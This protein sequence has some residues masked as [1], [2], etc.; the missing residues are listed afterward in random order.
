MSILNLSCD[1]VD[2]LIPGCEVE[3]VER[4][5][6]SEMSRVDDDAKSEANERTPLLQEQV[7]STPR[8]LTESCSMSGRSWRETSQGYRTLAYLVAI[9]RIWDC[10]KNPLKA[11]IWPVN[12]ITQLLGV[13]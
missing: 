4:L 12:H 1:F 8:E 13:N 10:S 7:Y 5:Q 9:G 11:H 6:V 3:K 2:S